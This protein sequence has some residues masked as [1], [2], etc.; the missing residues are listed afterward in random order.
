MTPARAGM[1]SHRA[2][3]KMPDDGL[4]VSMWWKT[5][6]SWLRDRIDVDVDLDIED[7]QVE[8]AVS[9]TVGQ[10]PV[11]TEHFSWPLPKLGGRQKLAGKTA[12]RKR[13]L[14]KAA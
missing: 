3:F 12:R 13:V 2:F 5:V 1:A 4:E 6:V 14:P 7:G 8:V 10:V 11:F 9:L